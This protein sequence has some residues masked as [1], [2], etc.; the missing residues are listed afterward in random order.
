MNGQT[1]EVTSAL[2][3]LLSQLKTGEEGVNGKVPSDDEIR[4]M[5]KFR[6]INEEEISGV[7]AYNGYAEVNFKSEVPIY[8]DRRPDMDTQYKNRRSSPN[9]GDL[10]ECPTRNTRLSDRILCTTVQKDMQPRSTSSRVAR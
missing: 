3:E 4:M 8:N 10:Q 9:L 7:E 2:L 6:E 5:C 1:D